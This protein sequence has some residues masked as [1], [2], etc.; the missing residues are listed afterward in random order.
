MGIDKYS[1]LKLKPILLN[2]LSKS[3]NSNPSLRQTL[4]G[5]LDN[6]AALV[7]G[8]APRV[9]V[10]VDGELR[11]EFVVEKYERYKV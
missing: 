6:G 9:V 2:I 1:L 4:Y 10:R 3:E 7:Q 5:V 11:T 8:A